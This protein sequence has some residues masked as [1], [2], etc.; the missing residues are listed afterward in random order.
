MSYP[1]GKLAQSFERVKSLKSVLEFMCA[2][3][4]MGKLAQSFEKV[5]SFTSVS[6]SFVSKL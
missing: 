6:W 3:Y 1:M 4:P 5:K 2:S